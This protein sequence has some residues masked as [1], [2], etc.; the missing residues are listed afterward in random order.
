MVTSPAETDHVA[1]GD[2]LPFDVQGAIADLLADPDRA[3]LQLPQLLTAEQR[4]HAKKVAG[5]YPEIRCESYGFG[6]DRQLHLFKRA[7][8]KD[9]PC[10]NPE[11]AVR[12]KNT[13][14]DDWVGSEGGQDPSEPVGFR[15]MPA[16]LRRSLLSIAI[17][18]GSEADNET[19]REASAS[20]ASNATPMG[21]STQ[22]LI[23]PASTSGSALQFLS[24]V[25]VRNTFIHMEEAPVSE[26]AVQSMPDNMFRECLLA[27]VEAAML[28]ESRERSVS[29]S[30]PATGGI[31]D[32][33][34]VL[35]ASLGEDTLVAG[36]QVVI[37]GLLKLVPFN[38]LEAS[39][40]RWDA[41]SGRYE[42][43]LNS[44]GPGGHQWVKVKREN[45]RQLSRAEAGDTVLVERNDAP[46]G[47][48]S[49]P[50]TSPSTACA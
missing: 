38:G 9:A 47:G 24:E 31:T 42:L 43:L 33:H 28:Q 4:K 30:T 44:V 39:V 5:L 12:V 45:L 15:S 49:L 27:E 21:E 22:S 8:A 23:S 35:P 19:F 7:A 1:H 41:E 14:I 32:A 46:N 20:L 25:Q 17:E 10:R 18:E 16:D 34:A 13:F 37:E 48:D 29:S 6:Q 26:R 3:S 36:T 40:Q 50:W 11:R 2:D